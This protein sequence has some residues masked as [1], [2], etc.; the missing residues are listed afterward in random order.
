MWQSQIGFPLHS[1]VSSPSPVWPV[2]CFHIQG[3]LFWWYRS[4]ICFSIMRVIFED[5]VQLLFYL[6]NKTVIRLTWSNHFN[7][8]PF[9]CAWSCTGHS[10]LTVLEK[11]CCQGIFFRLRTGRSGW[12]LTWV[13]FTIMLY[14]PICQGDDTGYLRTRGRTAVTRA[15]FGATAAA[16]AAARLLENKSLG[17]K[18]INAH[19]AALVRYDGHPSVANSTCTLSVGSLESFHFQQCPGAPSGRAQMPSPCWQLYHQTGHLGAV[20][21][22]DSQTTH[23]EM[24]PC[25]QPLLCLFRQWLDELGGERMLESTFLVSQTTQAAGAHTSGPFSALPG[26]V[27]DCFL[28]VV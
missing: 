15:A 13:P 7:S 3:F 28:L 21:V 24:I 16:A 12:S 27:L 17:Q 1:P 23:L 6:K 10:P 20:D 22:H 2:K 5:H 26:T 9:L 11:K 4:F 8:L 14:Q 25:C 19:P 18:P